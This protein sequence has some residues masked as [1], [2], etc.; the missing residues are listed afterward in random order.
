[1]R[2]NLFKKVEKRLYEY[3]NLDI[4]IEHLNI[5]MQIVGYSSSI[6][7]EKVGE[8]NKITNTVEDEVLRRDKEI[9]KIKKI[10]ELKELEKRVIENALQSLDCIEMEFFRLFYNSE[11]N[12]SVEFIANKL[13][14]TRRHMYRLREKVVHKIMKILYPSC[15][16]LN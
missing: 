3:K 6:Y 9:E 12:D 8:T 2:D 4:E 1:M 7:Q 5:Q 15:I 10:K 14:L 11:N 13:H 16:T